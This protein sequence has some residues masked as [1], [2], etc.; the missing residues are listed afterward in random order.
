MYHLVLEARPKEF[1]PIDINLL[2]GNKE[3]ES[4]TSLM[5][6]DKFTKKFT[7]EEIFIMIK[8]VNIVSDN[9]LN[10]TLDI[11]NDHKYRFGVIT[12]DDEFSLDTFFE[13]Y[14]D[15]K[16][17]M[18]KFY[19]V[20]IKYCSSTKDEMKSALEEKNLNKVLNVL[21]NNSYENVRCIY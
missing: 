18:N 13:K 2:L 1:M 4:Y 8:D 5:E 10:G 20:Y 15:D 21:F 17:I 7:K 6:I 9:Y 19:N 16:I 14:F 3:K 11:I 12:K